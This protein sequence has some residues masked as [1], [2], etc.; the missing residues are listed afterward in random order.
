MVWYRFVGVAHWII[1]APML[2][3]GVALALL[4]LLDLGDAGAH[5][6]LDGVHLGNAA[7]VKLTYQSLPLVIIM[8]VYVYTYWASFMIMGCVDKKKGGVYATPKG[9]KWIV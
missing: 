9:S 3:S 8:L 4:G 6:G 5:V 7:I 2:F 1:H